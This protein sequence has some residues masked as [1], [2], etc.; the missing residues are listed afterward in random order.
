MSRGGIRRSLRS[1]RPR[2]RAKLVL[3]CLVLEACMIQALGMYL[4]VPRHVRRTVRVRWPLLLFEKSHPLEAPG[5]ALMPRVTCHHAMRSHARPHSVC[6]AVVSPPP[7]PLRHLHHTCVLS[8]PAPSGALPART[9]AGGRRRRRWV[10][11]QEISV[12]QAVSASLSSFRHRVVPKSTGD[13]TPSF[14]RA[15]DTC[16]LLGG[17]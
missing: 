6:L 13:G 1:P 9:C 10:Q 14:T 15:R 16:I 7:A 2:R 8:H 4:V 17:I 12:P 3:A 11:L 5:E